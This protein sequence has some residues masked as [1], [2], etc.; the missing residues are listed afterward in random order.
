MNNEDALRTKRPVHHAMAVGV[1]DSVRNLSCEIQ[2]DIEGQRRTALAEVVIEADFVWL[3]TE[4]NRGAEFVFVE[5][6]STEDSGVNQRLQNLEFLEGC[7]ADGLVGRLVFAADFVDA[8]PA[9]GFCGGVFGLKILIREEGVLFDQ[10]L[11]DVVADMAL[12]LRRSNSRFIERLGDSSGGTNVDVRAAGGLVAVEIALQKRGK[13]SRS[14][15]ARLALTD[16]HSFGIRE[17]NANAGRGEEDQSLDPRCAFAS[18]RALLTEQAG[19]FAGLGVG[20]G[21]GAIHRNDVAVFVL[22]PEMAVAGDDTA[23]ALQFEKEDAGLRDGE[24]VDFVYGAV[25]GNEFEV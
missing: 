22:V 1:A 5:V 16:A 8:D 17:S 4:E 14:L 9:S 10:F 19:K 24:R 12:P 6:E 3:T 11:E 21:Q 18:K 20:Q 25:I 13:D 2:P 7:A 23:A 15:I